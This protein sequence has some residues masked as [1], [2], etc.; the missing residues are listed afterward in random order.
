M[1]WYRKKTCIRLTI[2]SSSSVCSRNHYNIQW[3]NLKNGTKDKPF[4]IDQAVIFYSYMPSFCFNS[5][6]DMNQRRRW[7]RPSHS[8]NA[9]ELSQATNLLIPYVFFELVFC[10]LQ[11]GQKIVFYTKKIITRL[12]I[13]FRTLF[14]ICL[15]YTSDAADE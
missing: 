1:Q 10:S 2:S 14:I 11:T 5:F 7:R 12:K 6:P 9:R 3:L 4:Y 8:C 13:V 15:L